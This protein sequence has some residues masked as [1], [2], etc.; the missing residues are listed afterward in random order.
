MVVSPHRDDAA[1]SLGLS[2]E[3]WLAAGHRV[4]VLNCFTQSDYAPYSDA[5]SL[6][7]NDRVSFVSA[8]RKREDAAWNKLLGGR[9]QFN[10]LDLLDA[11]LRL[12]CALDEVLTVEIRPGDRAQVRVVGAIAKLAR[13][14][15]PVVAAAPGVA[16][17]ASA[18]AFV[19][20]L[21]VGGHIDH[22]IVRQAGIE[23][24][25]A[26]PLPLAFYEDLPYAA[27]PEAANGIAQCAEAAGLLLGSTLLSAA[28]TSGLGSEIA[29]ARARKLRVAECYDS[30]IDSEVADQIAAFCESYAGRER[31]WATPAWLASSLASEG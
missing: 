9:L 1:F 30:Q 12:R 8:V 10:D 25:A 20:P 28:C 24:L 19:L 13:A 27:R 23:A 18:S 22:R 29:A 4:H 14:A 6:H 17:A 5:A 21:A 2:I 26:S 15:A 31:V 11:P 16:A 3:R 7:E